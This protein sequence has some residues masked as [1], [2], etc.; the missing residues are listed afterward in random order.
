[1]NDNHRNLILSNLNTLVLSTE[2]A[3]MARECLARDIITINM[4]T[5]IEKDAKTD[6]QRNKLLFKKITHRGPEAFNKLVQILREQQYEAAIKILE[7]S[8]NPSATFSNDD[9]VMQKDPGSSSSYLSISD[10][11]H[12]ME[13]QV[14]QASNHSNHSSR[15]S[16]FDNNDVVDN[17]EQQQMNKLEE[18]LAQTDLD[19]KLYSKPAKLK[20]LEYDKV[21]NFRIANLTEVRK[22]THFATHPKLGVYS[23]KSARRGVFF[24]VNIINFR[25]NKKRRGADEDREN[26]VALFQDMKYKVFYY[27]DLTGHQFDQLLHN[28]I[29]SDHLKN[30]DSFVMCVQTHGDLFGTGTMME[31]SDGTI[32][33]VEHCIKQFSNIDCEALANKP[34]IFFFPFCRGARSDTERRMKQYVKAGETPSPV[35][36]FPNNIETDGATPGLSTFSD[37]L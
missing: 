5:N 34:K 10:T 8:P 3:I 1:M 22:A 20:L 33:S 18:K 24:F 14:S 23:M 28:L 37:I 13:R 36:E 12:M 11:R 19:G 21:A 30:V 27:E 31:F 16:S 17:S 15:N 29:D 26:L 9:V 4:H 2:Y 35:D 6:N 25:T 32:S 7:D